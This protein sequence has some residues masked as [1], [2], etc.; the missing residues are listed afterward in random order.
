MDSL[1]Q[2]ALG[3]SVGEATMGRK[4]GNRAM[5]WGAI[6]GTLPDLDV[7]VP[8]GDAVKD[9]TYHRSA[10]HSLFVL[11]LLAPVLVW[12]I[13]RIHPDTR[14]HFK[15]LTLAMYSVFATH[16]LL[17][18]LTAYGTQIFWPFIT[19]PVSLS[20]VYIIDPLYT[21][22][23]LVGVTASLVMTRQTD[24]GHLI[25]RFGLIASSLYL[26]WTLIAKTIVDKNFEDALRDQG[27][28]HQKIF[29]TPSPF[30]S[31]LWRAVIRNQAGYYEAYYSLLDDDNDIRFSFFPSEDRLLT[32][33]A[34]HWPVQRLKW[35]SR[36]FYS[37]SERNGDIVIS[38]L[39]MGLEPSYVFQ[40]K[41]GKI[42]NPHPK[43]VSPERLTTDRDLGLLQLVWDR[44]WNQNVEISP[45]QTGH[46]EQMYSQSRLSKNS[47]VRR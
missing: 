46:R 25:N 1:T 17:D 21:L 19:T 9:F 5:L 27:I 29:T 40:F 38:D 22:P 41:V 20:S 10:S 2:L 8:L 14:A 32:E 37:V 36:G 3:A 24:R 43:P 42:S 28:A 34:D 47:P 45:A 31:L 4:I 18:C 6:A 30:N 11:A 23:L 26:S 16:V 33:I 12:A 15:R 35:F 39:R 13:T 7:F 44:I